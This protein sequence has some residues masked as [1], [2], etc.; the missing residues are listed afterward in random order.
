MDRFSDRWAVAEAE[1]KDTVNVNAAVESKS[2][3][4]DME[5]VLVLLA[6]L[7]QGP[8]FFSSSS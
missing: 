5:E 6:C 7:L 4:A 2:V 8:L 1:A 3:Q